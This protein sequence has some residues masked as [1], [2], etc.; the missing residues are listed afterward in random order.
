ML[1]LEEVDTVVRTGRTYAVNQAGSGTG[2]VD[3]DTKILT[4]EGF[5]IAGEIKTGD[6]VRTKEEFAN[7]W[8]QDIVIR[9]QEHHTESRFKFIFDDGE[10]LIAS[11]N[12]RLF[13]EGDYKEM[14]LFNVGDTVSNKTIEKIEE[15]GEGK[16][17][18]ITTEKTHTYISN[19]VLSHNAKGLGGGGGGIQ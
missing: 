1:L 12:H 7:K 5:I 9:V 15:V 17:F 13:Y 8:M 11:Y 16:V 14:I 4:P 19:G 6:I 18:E 10:S 2:C 3:Y